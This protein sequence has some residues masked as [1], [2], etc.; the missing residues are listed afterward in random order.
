ME[1]LDRVFVAWL[2]PVTD[3]TLK[4][5]EHL[6]ELFANL[7]DVCLLVLLVL[8]TD[9]FETIVGTVLKLLG[10]VDGFFLADRSVE[11]DVLLLEGTHRCCDLLHEQLCVDKWLIIFTEDFVLEDAKIFRPDDLVLQSLE[12][13]QSHI[14]NDFIVLLSV[15][16]KKIQDLKWGLLG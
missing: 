10:W 16:E 12:V 3:V 7:V 4:E 9:L 14:K 2:H 15:K 1:G 6:E 5:I 11:V 8:I 13:A